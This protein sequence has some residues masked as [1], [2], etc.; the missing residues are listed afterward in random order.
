MAAENTF[1]K[2]PGATKVVAVM[3]MDNNHNGVAYE[4]A[5]RTI[6]AGRTDWKLVFVRASEAFT[7]A[8]IEDADLFMAART[9]IEDPID[10]YPD[11]VSDHA[12]PGVPFWTDENTDA[13]VEELVELIRE[14]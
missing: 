8:L 3:A 2:K 6:L 4:T 12:E 11:A 5:L 1:P 10:L 13:V 9:G 14:L 7:P